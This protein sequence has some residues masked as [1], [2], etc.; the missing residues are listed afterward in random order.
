MFRVLC[1]E[2]LLSAVTILSLEVVIK[3]LVISV[4]EVAVIVAVFMKSI[5][6]IECNKKKLSFCCTVIPVKSCYFAIYYIC[7]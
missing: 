4:F 2:L 5:R 6:D 1:L 3:S 7:T